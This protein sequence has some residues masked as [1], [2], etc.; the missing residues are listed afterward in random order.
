MSGFDGDWR[1]CQDNTKGCPQGGC[2]H[3]CAR[4]AQDEIE[5]LT[6]ERPSLSEA[7]AT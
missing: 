5:R 3:R 2:E 4:D 6:G 1:C 7:N